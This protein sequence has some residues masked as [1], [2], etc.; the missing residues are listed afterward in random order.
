VDLVRRYDASIG[1]LAKGRARKE[2]MSGG[3]KFC[4]LIDGASLDAARQLNQNI[5]DST[6]D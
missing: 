4:P 1:V 2:F 3:S 5:S 6:V